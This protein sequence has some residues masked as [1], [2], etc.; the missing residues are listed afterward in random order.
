MPRDSN[1]PRMCVCALQVE[2]ALETGD[3]QAVMAL[4]DQL[5]DVVSTKREQEGELQARLQVGSFVS[6]E[7]IKYRGVLHGHKRKGQSGSGVSWA[8]VTWN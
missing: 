4:R 7:V 2:R 3:P 8:R 1:K 5:E 6:L